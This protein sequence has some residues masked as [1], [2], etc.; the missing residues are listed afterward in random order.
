MD[1][2]NS[3]IAVQV[4][5]SATTGSKEVEVNIITA[6]YQLSGSWRG[7]CLFV[8]VIRGICKSYSVP[9]KATMNVDRSKYSSYLC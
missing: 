6:F 9:Q 5:S 1:N 2:K 7:D 4:E 8:N 3:D